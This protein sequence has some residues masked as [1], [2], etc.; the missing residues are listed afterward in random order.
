MIR[1]LSKEFMTINAMQ[2]MA[3]DLLPEPV[4]KN[5]LLDKMIFNGKILYFLEQ[6]M[7]FKK[8][9][10]LIGYTEEQYKW[11]IENE[12]HIW[13]YFIEHNLLFNNVLFEHQKYVTDGPFTIGMPDGAP[14]K[15][16]MWTG[17]QIVKAYMDKSSNTTLPQLFA[18]E[19]A[20]KILRV[21]KYKPRL[22]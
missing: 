5:S 1:R 22:K 2:V 4:Q 12:P 21:S 6:T 15:I 7:P 17:W 3:T 11:C 19:D 8:K 20:H 18:E 13:A 9:H 10:D 16:A 14:G